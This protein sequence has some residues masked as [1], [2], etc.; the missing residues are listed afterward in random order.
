Q[1]EQV[2]LPVEPVRQRAD[3]LEGTL[4]VEREQMHVAAA[5]QLQLHREVLRRLPRPGEEPVALRHAR[6]AVADCLDVV[7]RD[8]TGALQKPESRAGPGSPPAPSRQRSRAGIARRA[9]A[10]V[11]ATPSSRSAGPCGDSAADTMP[12]RPRRNPYL[13][14]LRLSVDHAALHHEL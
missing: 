9:S 12:V 2:L 3:V 4:T 1:V 6:V 7:E 10:R 5:V 14:R 8:A 11:P 13:P